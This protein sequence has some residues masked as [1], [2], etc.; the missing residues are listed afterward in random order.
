MR[1]P[2]LRSPLPAGCAAA[3]AFACAA[4]PC[5]AG[6]TWRPDPADEVQWTHRDATSQFSARVA[7]AD[8]SAP[9]SK[10]KAEAQWLYRGWS[11]HQLRLGAQAQR[12]LLLPQSAGGALLGASAQDEW[13]FA[14]DWRLTVGARGDAAPEADADASLS[15]RAALLWQLLPELSL[16]LLDGVVWRDG[17]QPL[18]VDAAP[19]A[20]PAT[21]LASE[22][23]RATELALN[24]QPAPMLRFGASV[25]LQKHD[26]LAQP[27]AASGTPSAAL[28]Y[29]SLGPSVAGQG[30]GLDGELR[31]AAA[32]RLRARWAE[33][34]ERD[35]DDGVGGAAR[36]VAALQAGAPLPLAGAHVGLEW[37]RVE[38]RATQQALPSQSLLNASLSWTPLASPWSIAATAYN[39]VDHVPDEAWVPSPQDLLVREGRRFQLQVARSF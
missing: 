30:L 15:P 10:L 11:G 22:R 27:V 9:G 7:R 18:A 8:G 1:P 23:L 6:D 36:R 17:G 19:V 12:D 31:V 38:R 25:R 39:L 35:G 33:F 28:Q 16:R 34:D 29:Q 21:P 20:V 2:L 14:P 13:S 26:A 5:R 4:W 24:W 32:W 3:L 37:T